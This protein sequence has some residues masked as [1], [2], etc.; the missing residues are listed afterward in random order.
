MDLGRFAQGGRDVIILRDY[1]IEAPQF[2][3]AFSS[4]TLVFTPASAIV[5]EVSSKSIWA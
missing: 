2:F 5:S 1:N 3:D 4:R